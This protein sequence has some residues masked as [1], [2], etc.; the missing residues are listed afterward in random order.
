M[1]KEIAVLFDNYGFKLEDNMSQNSFYKSIIDQYIRYKRLYTVWELQNRC[2]IA[3][4]EKGGRNIWYYN[5][6]SNKNYIE[7]ELLKKHL[8]E[9]DEDH[10]EFE[11]YMDG[12]IKYTLDKLADSGSIVLSKVMTIYHNIR[13]FFKEEFEEKFDYSF[14]NGNI[15]YYIEYACNAYIIYKIDS[16]YG[17][18]IIYSIYYNRNRFR[19]RN[20]VQLSEYL[21]K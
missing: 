8:V 18:K 1:R 6:I 3:I 13:D 16:K 17:K 7:K 21:S 9:V 19:D 20:L 14:T 11:L 4:P 12:M 2:G 5:T 10:K 15:S